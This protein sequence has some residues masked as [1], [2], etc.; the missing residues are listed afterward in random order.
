MEWADHV[1]IA[2]CANLKKLCGSVDVLKIMDFGDYAWVC[3]TARC[4][5]LSE[6]PV[7]ELDDDD[8]TW[9]AE[10]VNT[11]TIGRTSFGAIFKSI[12]VMRGEAALH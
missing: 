2:K 1:P 5:T 3:D 10:H 11:T 9:L 6:K 12:V 4:V 8:E 7:G